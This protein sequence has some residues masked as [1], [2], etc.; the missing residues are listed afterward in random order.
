M[1]SIALRSTISLSRREEYPAR[2]EYLL[3]LD[4]RSVFGVFVK[5]IVEFRSCAQVEQGC[6]VR[7]EINSTLDEN[8]K[9]HTVYRFRWGEY[10]TKERRSPAKQGT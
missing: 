8:Y 10:C 7:P 5:P 2:L 3:A 6:A 4:G 1:A 9:K